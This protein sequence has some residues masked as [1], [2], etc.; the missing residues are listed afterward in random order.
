[1]NR[2]G[3]TVDLATIVATLLL[4]ACQPLSRPF[5][6]QDGLDQTILRIPDG[7]GIY[8]VTP[9]S[10]SN[11]TAS[12]E[13]MDRLVNGMVAA[14]HAADIVA[15]QGATRNPTS[16]VLVPQILAP[17]IREGGGDGAIVWTL[18]SPDGQELTHVV[19]PGTG[20]PALARVAE[21]MAAI[22]TKDE[23]QRDFHAP[24]I[25]GPENLSPTAP[26]LGQTIA[27]LIEGETEVE[28]SQESTIAATNAALAPEAPPETSM[29]LAVHV[30]PVEGAPGTGNEDLTEA[31]YA[32]LGETDEIVL[33][34]ADE[35]A[36]VIRGHVEIGPAIGGEQSVEI[37]W[38]LYD[39]SGAEI[40]AIDQA[41]RVPQGSLDG[42]WGGAARQIALAAS[43]GL[44]DLLAQALGPDRN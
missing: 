26:E 9:H 25:G 21:V 29:G 2:Y 20:H 42:R 14:L 6:H 32:V 18:T 1:M 16:F 43:V 5:A 27:G 3:Y 31:M 28:T 15:T 38:R 39:Q 4:T 12:S 23:I 37:V 41:N 34:G 35:E 22:V 10:A 17:Q 7:A 8:V 44:A 19:E 13:T 24:L 36:L 11:E 40:G 30:A 33:V